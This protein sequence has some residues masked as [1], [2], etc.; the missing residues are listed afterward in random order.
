MLWNI[1]INC[2]NPSE[3]DVADIALSLDTMVESYDFGDI[4]K[5]LEQY[6]NEYVVNDIRV[7]M[8]VKFR[9]FIE[10]V[11]EEAPF[12]D[13]DFKLTLEGLNKQEAYFWYKYLESL[14]EGTINDYSI[15]VVET[16]AE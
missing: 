10:F 8:I 6:G 15:E 5:S 9:S 11:R 12:V 4:D 3:Y 1:H 13:D 2:G 14:Y 7:H 16:A